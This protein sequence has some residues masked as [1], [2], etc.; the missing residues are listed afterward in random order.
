ME[1]DVDGTT[2]TVALDQGVGVLDLEGATPSDVV[3]E[4]EDGPIFARAEILYGRAFRA[5]ETPPLGVALE[6]RLGAVGVPAGFEVQVAANAAVGTPVVDIQLPASAVVDEGF[7]RAV[8]AASSVRKVEVREPGFL[9]VHLVQLRDGQAVT[10]AL[11]F[12]RVSPSPVSGLGMV[13]Y[14]AAS[15]AAMTVVPP[16]RIGE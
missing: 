6:G 15:P 11:P 12:V 4:S 10:F 8:Q 13:A 9:R 14:P 7:L 16:R 3:V 2:H 5:S 1:V